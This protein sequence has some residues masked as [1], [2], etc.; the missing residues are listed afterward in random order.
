MDEIKARR[1]ERGRGDESSQ[2]GGEGNG[3][4]EFVVGCVWERGEDDK[5]KFMMKG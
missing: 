3:G 4:G 1:E 2:S 5:G